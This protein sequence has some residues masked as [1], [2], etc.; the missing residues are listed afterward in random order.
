V[1]ASNFGVLNPPELSLQNFKHIYDLVIGAVSSI[2]T[3]LL[4][5]YFSKKLESRKVSTIVIVIIV[6]VFIIVSNYF[7]N[8]LVNGSSAFRRW[9][10][11]NNYIEGYWFETSPP[12]TNN[13]IKHETFVK[14]EY[15]DGA[16]VISGETFDSS[17]RSYANFKSVS[18]AY[19]NGILYFQYTSFNQTHGIGQ[20]FD[21]VQFDSPPN[22]YKAFIFSSSSKRYYGTDGVRID[23]GQVEAYKDFN[24]IDDKRKFISEF[25][26]RK[27]R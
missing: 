1:K 24:T 17:G 3:A 7:V 21:Q 22:S 4:L 26:T 8:N 20:G 16:Y 14:I 9:I 19:Y 13:I 5:G 27:A 23:K 18:S 15:N 10:D 25:L 6:S 12:D 11:P 2:G